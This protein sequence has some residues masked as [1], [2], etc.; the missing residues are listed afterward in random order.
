MGR[1]VMQQPA[2]VGG[3][4]TPG[5]RRGGASEQPEILLHPLQDGEQPGAAHPGPQ[6]IGHR[7]RPH[8]T[9]G[10]HGPCMGQDALG[11]P[12]RISE[13]RQDVGG[14]PIQSIGLPGQGETDGAGQLGI[15]HRGP[16]TPATAGRPRSGKAASPVATTGRS[17]V[18]SPSTTKDRAP[19]RDGATRTRDWN[20]SISR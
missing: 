15:A 9:T 12:A 20:S 6:R 14:D 1:D 10:Q 17:N 19:F 18:Q 8:P 13:R 16:S 3:Q 7:V 4:R 2:L 11:V 5:R